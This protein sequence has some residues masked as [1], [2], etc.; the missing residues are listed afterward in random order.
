VLLSGSTPI[1]RA[2]GHKKAPLRC[3]GCLTVKV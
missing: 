1:Y 2:A 3:N